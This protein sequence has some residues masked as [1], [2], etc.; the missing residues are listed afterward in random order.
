MPVVCVWLCVHFS[1]DRLGKLGFLWVPGSQ[2][3]F[4]RHD[5]VSRVTP[6]TNSLSVLETRTGFCTHDAG[7]EDRLPIYDTNTQCR[8]SSFSFHTMKSS[9]PRIVYL[10]LDS[11]HHPFYT[12]FRGRF[13]TYKC[14]FMYMYMHLFTAR[15]QKVIQ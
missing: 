15:G 9:F 11:H 7:G 6:N 2:F 14:M 10:S 8:R 4:R 13:V 1:P 12:C 5:S 3:A